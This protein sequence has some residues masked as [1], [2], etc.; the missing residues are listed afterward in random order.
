MSN[1]VKPYE[2]TDR[3]RLTALI[4]N[5]NE[6]TWQE[7][8]DFEYGTAINPSTVDGAN[9]SV[10]LRSKLTN[11]R[12]AII[13]YERLDIGVLSLLPPQFLNTVL[14]DKLPFEIHEILEDINSALGLTLSTDEVVNTKFHN[15]RGSYPLNI[16]DG[17]SY[18]WL[19][20]MYE[21]IAEF[22]ID[23][24]TVLRIT[25]LNGLHPPAPKEV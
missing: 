15:K 5:T 22:I 2:G 20:S 11:Y 14:I 25:S 16:V 13:H 9:T 17:K 1:T 6:T 10:W 18:A 21:F 8:V 12:D 7:G 24:S 4:N 23:L 3:D 19:P